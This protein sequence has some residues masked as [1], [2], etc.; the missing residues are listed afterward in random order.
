MHRWRSLLAVLISA[1]LLPALAGCAVDQLYANRAGASTDIQER[2][3]AAIS[4]NGFRHTLRSERDDSHHFD[5]I[6]ISVPLDSL[7]RRHYSLDNLLKE[8][9]RICA[10]PEYSAYPIF[11]ELGA[12]DEEDRLFLREAL[13]RGAGE[14][15]NIRI[16][17]A[18][19]DNHIAIVVNHR[20][21]PLH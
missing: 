11:I 6:H 5:T 1:F 18:V 2:L 14:K 16:S 3:S 19:A 8:V 13:L 17:A 21:K 9:G 15:A 10:L 12:N 7:K 4:R 20:D